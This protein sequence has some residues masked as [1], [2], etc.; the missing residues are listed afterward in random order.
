MET[1]IDN[2]LEFTPECKEARGGRELQIAT[3]KFKNVTIIE[4]THIPFN[5][6]K[7]ITVEYVLDLVLPISTM[8]KN[9]YMSESYYTAEGYGTPVFK[10]DLESAIE[11][12]NNFFN[13]FYINFNMFFFLFIN[14]I[15]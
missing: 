3:T 15:F 2:L 1:I 12:I 7:N 5:P 13:S 8:V 14:Q 11:F 10:N 6:F 9:G 4:R